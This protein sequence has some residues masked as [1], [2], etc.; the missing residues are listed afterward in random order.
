[1]NKAILFLIYLSS[2]TLWSLSGC[3]NNNRT[4]IYVTDSNDNTSSEIFTIP[5][6][7]VSCTVTNRHSVISTTPTVTTITTFNIPNTITL[8]ST[9]SETTITDIIDVLPTTIPDN[10]LCINNLIIYL[11]YADATQFNID[12]YDVVYSTGYVIDENT[13]FEHIEPA[14]NV[15]PYTMLFGHDYK[16]FSILPNLMPGE[17]FHM[18]VQGSSVTYEIQRSECGYDSDDGATI[19]SYSDNIDMLFNDYGYEALI[20]ITCHGEDRWVIVAKPI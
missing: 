8:S 19:Y 3:T 7:T 13:E 1:M 11:T 17:L 18:N 20:L 16:S 4:N 9:I 12:N 10:T 2:T 6:T 15:Y 5:N 14:E